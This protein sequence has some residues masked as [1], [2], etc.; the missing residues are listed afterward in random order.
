MLLAIGLSIVAFSQTENPV[1]FS[2][3]PGS[4]KRIVLTPNGMPK[5][6]IVKSPSYE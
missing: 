5:L 3:P 1:G 2:S 4:G 6:S